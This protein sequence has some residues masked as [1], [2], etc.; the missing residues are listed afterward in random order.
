[1]NAHAP[2]PEDGAET[3]EEQIIRLSSLNFER[4]PMLEVVFDRYVM[5]LASAM[6]SF[7]GMPFDVTLRSFDYVTCGTALSGLPAP[8]LSAL[9]TATPWSGNV[10]MT[11]SPDLL[12]SVLEVM[13]GG[14]EGRG[15][16]L[17]KPRSFTAIERRFGGRLARMILDEFSQ[18]FRQ[19]SEV[20]FEIDSLESAP[21]TIAIAP[22]GSPAVWVTLDLTVGER[23]GALYFLIPYTA[24]DTVRPVLNQ[25]FLGGKIGGDTSWRKDLEE[26]I[27]DTTVTLTASLHRLRVPVQ[28]ALGWRKGQTIDLGISAEQPVDVVCGERRMF[29]GQ[30]GR[31]ATGQVAL[32]LIEE[33]TGTEADDADFATD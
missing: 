30:M 15:R 27:E 25:P 3:V 29:R 14:R 33:D 5:A 6:K 8:S 31:R 16:Q 28:E 7:S 4:M 12:F 19:L 24:L 22:S 9:T 21:E 32:R 23:G 18:S 1:M 17:W 11:L 13:L 10:L 26:K 2:Q 20:S